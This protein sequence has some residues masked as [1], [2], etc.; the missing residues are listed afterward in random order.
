MKPFA[1]VLCCIVV[2]GCGGKGAEAPK[3]KTE[4]PTPIL[5]RTTQDVVDL[6]KEKAKFKKTEV[7]PRATDASTLDPGRA[8]TGVVSKAAKLQIQHAIRLFHAT[9]GR[10]PKDYDEFMREIIKRNHI[11]LPRLTT[12]KRYAYDSEKHEL[13]IVTAR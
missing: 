12:G 11:K 8:Y 5:R 10:Y 6:Q 9:N 2:A 4:K 3:K 13:V 1:W 7:K